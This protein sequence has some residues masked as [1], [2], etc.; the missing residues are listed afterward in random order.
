PQITQ[1]TQKEER[2][3]RRCEG[4]GRTIRVSRQGAKFAKQSKKLFFATLRASSGLTRNFLSLHTF[5]GYDPS[6]I[7][8]LPCLTI[9][10]IC[11]ICGFFLLQACPY[12]TRRRRSNSAFCRESARAETRA[13]EV[14]WHRR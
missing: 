2:R 12:F 3:L 9:R 13:G 7:L 4:I 11:E 14:V 5:S 6:A 1:I 10:A 8:P